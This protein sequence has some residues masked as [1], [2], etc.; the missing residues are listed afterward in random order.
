[1][2][3]Y[4][5]SSIPSIRDKNVLGLGHINAKRIIE[6]VIRYVSNAWDTQ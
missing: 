4:L 1:M 3:E 2:F 5:H 6:F